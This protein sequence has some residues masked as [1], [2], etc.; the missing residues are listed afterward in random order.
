MVWIRTVPVADA[1][2]TLADAYRRQD[3]A[4]DLSPRRQDQW[5]GTGFALP[6]R[7]TRPILVDE[8]RPF[9]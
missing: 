9:G 6:F 8:M 2:G 5:P 3:P 7:A 1:T 4:P